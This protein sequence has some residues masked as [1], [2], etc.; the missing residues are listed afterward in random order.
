MFVG[1][2]LL[3]GFLG[4]P[5]AY[6]TDFAWRFHAIWLSVAG[7]A[8]L[9]P[10]SRHL[11]L[12]GVPA[13]TACA[14]PR[15]RK[16]DSVRR[17]LVTVVTV[18]VVWLTSVAVFLQSVMTMQYGLG[19]DWNPFTRAIRI[20]KGGPYAEYGFIELIMFLSGFL[21]ITGLIW[22]PMYVFFEWLEARRLNSSLAGELD[23]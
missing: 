9:I 8:V 17:Y 10:A 18:T 6:G 20:T 13:K 14:W 4:F 21:A 5:F 2:L 22:W 15:N 3:L 23:A 16:T 7:I 19:A 12:G 1:L 11:L